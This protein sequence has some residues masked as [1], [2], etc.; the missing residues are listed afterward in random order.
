MIESKVF[1]VRDR[2]TMILVLAVAV[3]AKE[4]SLTPWEAKA[5]RRSGYGDSRLIL[6]TKLDNGDKRIEY[7]AFA[8]DRG[9]TMRDAHRFIEENW[10]KLESGEVIDVEFI[11]GETTTKKESEL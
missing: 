3:G 4:P 10:L 8:W 6:L 2:A 7:D 9:R 5:V 1:E 11:V